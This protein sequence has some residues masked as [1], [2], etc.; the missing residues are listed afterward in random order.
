MNEE[1]PFEELS[2]KAK[3]RAN[4]GHY[5][6]LARE[7]GL[8]DAA[9]EISDTISIEDPEVRGQTSKEFDD[10]KRDDIRGRE[11]WKEQKTLPKQDREPTREGK[12]NP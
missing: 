2:P 7:H 10:S 11:M 6:A 4:A 3:M 1:R 8:G 12:R 9:G 5:E